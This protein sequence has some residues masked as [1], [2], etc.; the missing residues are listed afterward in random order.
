MISIY[1]SNN[2]ALKYMKQKVTALLKEIEKLTIK[3][4]P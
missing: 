3:R 2:T 4:F 1:E